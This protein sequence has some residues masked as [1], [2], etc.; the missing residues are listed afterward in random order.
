[1]DI[2][3]SYLRRTSCVNEIEYKIKSNQMNNTYSIETQHD[4]AFDDFCCSSKNYTLSILTNKQQ[5][6]HLV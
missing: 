5:I 4:L 1:M 3:L 2:H 6:V